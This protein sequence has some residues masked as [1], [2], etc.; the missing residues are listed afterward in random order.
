MASP[1]P[2][3]SDAFFYTSSLDT[4]ATVKT[5]SLPDGTLIY[6]VSE[7]TLYELVKVSTLPAGPGVV[8][9][10]GGPGRFIRGAQTAV[11]FDGGRDL[12]GGT[13]QVPNENLRANRKVPSPIDNGQ[14]G[15]VNLCSVDPTAPAGG[16]FAPYCTISGG[17]NN[18]IGPDGGLAA[19]AGGFSNSVD[20]NFGAVGGGA[21][22]TVLGDS[23][24]AAG[25]GNLAQ[26]DS[27]TALGF[28]CSAIGTSS[29]AAG[30][31]S[32]ALGD[33]SVAFDAGQANAA[34][35]FAMGGTAN[36]D[37]SSAFLTCTADGPNS[38]AEGLT[39]TAS[40]LASHAEGSASVASGDSSHAEGDSCIASGTAGSHAEGQANSAIGLATHVEGQNNIA[41]ADTSHIEGALNTNVASGATIAGGVGSH[42]EGVQGN[43]RLIACHTH[44]IIAA[45]I[46][47]GAAQNT[48][49]GLFGISVE[50]APIDLGVSGLPATLLDDTE[51]HLEDNKV[52]K[53]KVELIAHNRNATT[54][55]PATVWAEWD[56]SFLA[57][58]VGGVAT[59]VGAP[60][61]AAP[62]NESP[63]AS[64]WTVTVTAAG[65]IVHFTFTGAALDVSAQAL[66]YV[67]FLELGNPTF[68]PP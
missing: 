29:F 12:G 66:A 27:S 41:N 36:G 31:F 46:T 35:A 67:H 20:A 38:F 39:T 18:A 40:G 52:Y 62:D 16:A 59:V 58:M 50:G 1:P 47:Q 30:R 7:T 17:Q 61:A 25:E 22:N 49:V 2:I 34:N 55:A 14:N 11:I 51:I 19:I 45:S 56:F 8:L 64:G 26:G 23:G 32:V 24:F 37:G 33:G 9:P 43:A 13:D 4:L 42:T 10:A 3:A 65:D 68:S 15:I 6:V 54:D 21:Q 5:N 53:F 48:D 44:G 60:V 63:G 28:L 57:F